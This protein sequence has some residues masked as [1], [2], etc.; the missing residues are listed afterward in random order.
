MH[1]AAAPD[2]FGPPQVDVSK[3]IS[4]AE[5]HCAS[6]QKPPKASPSAHSPNLGLLDARAT[7]RTFAELR[8]V[9]L[10][11]GFL[12]LCS[13]IEE[14]VLREKIVLVG[15]YEKLP[16]QYRD[17][18]KQFVDEHV[19]EICVER[20]TIRKLSAASPK[21]LSASVQVP[22]PGCRAQPAPNA[23]FEVPRLLAA[24]QRLR[25]PTIALLRHLHNSGCTRRPHIDHVACDLSPRFA[26]LRSIAE[27][28]LRAEALRVRIAHISM[29]PIA[30]EVMQ[31]SRTFDAMPEEI[32]EVRRK[33]Q[34]LRRELSNLS[35][36]LIS[37]RL[38]Y[39]AYT[40]KVRSLDLGWAAVAN[41]AINCEMGVGLTALSMLNDG[42][43]ML[44]QLAT[45]DIADAAPKL[46]RIIDG[47]RTPSGHLMFRPVHRSVRNYLR[48]GQL[49]KADAVGQL[50][51][52]DPQ[53]ARRRLAALG[54][55]TS[56]W[57]EAMA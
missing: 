30:L 55:T 18:L 37:P 43:D 39:E 14:M 10:P 35:E 3:C 8:S 6:L 2:G 9:F 7:G 4:P 24:E 13:M 44:R 25:I 23:N 33:Y 27:E 50:F 22:S 1:A 15:K 28:R 12:D 42:A 34:P 53:L 52:I 19:F 57:H 38:G 17:A 26:Q 48:T 49:G 47:A 21:L 40:R 29:P 16:R 36:Q 32:L 20:L 46:A 54:D 5:C 51:E 11:V 45:L 31:R 41:Q 56:V